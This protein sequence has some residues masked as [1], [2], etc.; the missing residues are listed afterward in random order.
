VGQTLTANT[1]SLGGTGTISYQWKRGTVNVGANSSAYTVE[2]ADA[3]STITVTVTRSGNSGSV[4]SAPTATVTLPALTGTVSISGTAQA[5]ETLTANTGSL[6]GTGT[7]S[8]QWKRGTANAGADSDTYT[9]ESADVGSTITVTVTRSENSGSVTSAATAVVTAGTLTGTVSISGTAQVG[10]TLTANTNNL[11][12]SGTF[13]YQWKKSGIA[14][15]G[16]NSSLYKVESTDIGYSITVTVTVS[17]YS[18]SITSAPTA[19][20]PDPLAAL[21]GRWLIPMYPG[22]W[23]PTTKALRIYD[24]NTYDL[25]D[26]TGFLPSRVTGNKFT[27]NGNKLTFVHNEYYEDR[28]TIAAFSISDDG[29]TLTITEEYRWSG[30]SINYSGVYTKV[31][32]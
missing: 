28:N 26:N 5:G 22:S 18:G 29:T 11:N 20:V 31:D 14:I 21:Q 3:D 8:Y 17:G 13:T 2:T 15:S 6:G 19:V 7:I 1:G 32:W 10:M 25:D 16:A 4:T 24:G 30:T 12:G 27:V 23:S 9:V